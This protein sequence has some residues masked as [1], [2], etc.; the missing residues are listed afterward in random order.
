[1]QSIIDY[2]LIGTRIKNRRLELN[3]TQNQLSQKAN[4]SITYVSK[5]EHGHVT[6]T[7]E[8]YALLA[9]IL[10]T[11]LSKLITGS[12]KISKNYI[13]HE[14]LEICKKATNKQLSLI[15]KIA[16]TIIND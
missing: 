7:L 9:E 5:I 16:E 10:Q 11:D 13:N 3:L 12:S 8:T 2:K 4:I 6:P 15:I 1:M 14:L